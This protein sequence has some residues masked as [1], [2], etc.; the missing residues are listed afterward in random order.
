V[1][2]RG[3]TIERVLELL[4]R[5][6]GVVSRAQL[7]ALGHRPHDIA[8][9]LRR[10]EL[11]RLHPGV[12]IDHTGEPNWS[13]RAWAAVL[14]CQ[15]VPGG[16][17]DPESA[18]LHR[19]SALTGWDE[20]VRTPRSISVVVADGRKVRTPDGVEVH[21]SSRTLELVQWHLS[22]P[23]VRYEEAVIEVAARQSRTVDL[24]AEVSRAVGERRTTAA[25]LRAC[26]DERSRVARRDLLTGVLDDVATGA[27]SVLE[28]GYLTRVERPHGLPAARRQ[29]RGRSRTSVTYRDADY[30]GGGGGAGRAGLARLRP[31]SGAGRRP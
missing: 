5:Q 13:Q 24:V 8:R 10:R 22:P 20:V 1:W 2:G 7:L 11:T 31:P 14:H 4:R 29:R 17:P 21:R 30:D 9:L 27:C 12:F 16:Q 23:R 3:T 26:L 18:A 25:R 15:H 19:A 6:C 28:H